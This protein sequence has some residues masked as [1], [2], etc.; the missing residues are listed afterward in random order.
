M[1]IREGFVS[2]SSSTSFIVTNKTENTLY[3]RDLCLEAM[4]LLRQ[5]NEEYHYNISTEDYMKDLSYED[6]E[7]KP[8][9]NVLVFGDENGGGY[10]T[11][12]DYMMRD[13]GETLS[14]KWKFDKFLR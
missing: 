6:E 10:Q 4:F 11:V 14:F 1:K 12:F 3:V 13:G 8:G 9:R 7:I 2:N 5:F